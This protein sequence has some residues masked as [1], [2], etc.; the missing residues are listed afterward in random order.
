MTTNLI[1]RSH[2]NLDLKILNKI[3]DCCVSVMRLIVKFKKKLR[4]SHVPKISKVPTKAR[5]GAVNS[6]AIR[7]TRQGKGVDLQLTTGHGV[8][9]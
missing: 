8:T 3:R 5:R 9:K 1:V 4:T 6:K 2:L 7:R